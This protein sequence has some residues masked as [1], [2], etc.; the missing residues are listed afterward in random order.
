MPKKSK[1]R[2]SLVF[3]GETGSGKTTLL[4]SLKDTIYATPYGRSHPKKRASVR[5]KIYKKARKAD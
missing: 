4:E 2:D 5:R 3:V 1:Q